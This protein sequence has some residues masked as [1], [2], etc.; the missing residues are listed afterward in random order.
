[1][2]LGRVTRLWGVVRGQ[3]SFAGGVNILSPETE[4]R[5]RA[6]DSRVCRQDEDLCIFFGGSEKGFIMEWHQVQVV[7]VVAVLSI[8]T[9]LLEKREDVVVFHE[10]PG[11]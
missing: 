2:A 9:L 1:M 7:L 10:Q 4:G 8:H 5:G 6:I 11:S 3:D